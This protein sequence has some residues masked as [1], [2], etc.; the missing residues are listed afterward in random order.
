MLK[1]PALQNELERLNDLFSLNLLDTLCEQRFDHV[2]NLAKRVL[3]TEIAYLAL[4][5]KNRQWFKSKCGITA[6]E[7]G[8][9]ESFC[10]HTIA[11]NQL[12][13]V[14]DTLLDERFK[15][16][17]LVM[18]EPF[19]RFYAGYPLQGPNGLNIGTFCIADSS[20]RQLSES[21]TQ[22]LI[23]FAALAQRELNLHDVIESQNRL[24]ELQ[25]QLEKATKTLQAEVDEAA[26]F[27]HQKLPPRFEDEQFKLDWEFLACSQLGGDMF[28]FEKIGDR[29][30]MIYLLDVA[31]HGIGASLLAV[32]AQNTLRQFMSK[33]QGIVSPASILSHLNN[34]FEMSL[35]QDR[36]FTMWCGVIDLDDRVMHYANAGH[37]APVL[38]SCGQ[39]PNAL[40][41]SSLMIGVSQDA[42]YTDLQVTLPPESRLIL[43]SDGIIEEINND[44]EQFGRQRLQQAYVDRCRTGEC[45][46]SAITNCAREFNGQRPFA[47]DLSI[48]ELTIK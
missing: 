48:V 4:I 16:N 8:R 34:H 20:P 43:Y 18:G 37:P 28:G 33:V 44:D 24:L 19:V 6:D 25:S 41:Q 39:E 11:Q 36:F 7:T 31:G 21:E 46:L 15:D 26:D 47:D 45:D 22:L 30:F 9:D 10:G 5:D 42:P 1:A 38:F 40:S 29:Q 12:M 35:N 3:D 32:S 14:P 2:V 23:D 13:V 17:P 27:I